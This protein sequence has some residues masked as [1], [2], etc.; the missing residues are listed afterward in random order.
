[1]LHINFEVPEELDIKLLR[2]LIQTNDIIIEE[3]PG[4]KPRLFTAMSEDPALF[5]KLGGIV[6]LQVWEDTVS[7]VLNLVE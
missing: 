2:A 4:T 6:I 3:M 1:M 7:Q 5:Y